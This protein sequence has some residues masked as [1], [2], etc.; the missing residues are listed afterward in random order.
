L[1]NQ[2]KFLAASDPF[3]WLRVLG[4]GAGEGFLHGFAGQKLFISA[5]IVE[6][7]KQLLEGLQFAP[8]W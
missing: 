1:L 5:L 4:N 7:E 2:S 3:T 6:R 8:C